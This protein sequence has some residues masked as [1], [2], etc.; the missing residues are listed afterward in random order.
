[1]DP[2]ELIA[3]FRNLRGTGER[4]IAIAHSHPDGPAELSKTD[5]EQAYYPEAA[6]LIISLAELNSPQA[7][8]FRIIDG[9]ALPIELHVIV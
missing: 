4:L 8:A 2:Q 9:Q 6:H 1:M 5:I 3:A 7:V